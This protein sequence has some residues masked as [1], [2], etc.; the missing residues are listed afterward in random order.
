[1]MDVSVD[2][3]LILRQIRHR[4]VEIC[5]FIYKQEW[6]LVNEYL[7]ALDLEYAKI[8]SEYCEYRELFSQCRICAQ[9]E[10][11]MRLRDLL[12]HELDFC[13]SNQLFMVNEKERKILA[14][15]ARQENEEALEMCHKDIWELIQNKNSTPRIEC[16][17]VGTENVS[18][19]VKQ[20]DCKFR[21]FSIMSPW[22]EANGLL[23]SL[24]NG[25]FEEIHVL[26]F[27]GGYLIGELQRKFREAKI[28]VYLP[29]IDIFQAV[30]H[31][32]SV[33]EILRN[34]NLKFYYDPAC[35]IFIIAL[36]GI[37]K[38]NK[39][40]G[41]YIDQQELRSCRENVA[42]VEYWVRMYK[43]EYS[44]DDI[45]EKNETETVG[46]RINQYI[47]NFID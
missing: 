19:S 6:D 41:I 16:A 7:S 46:K 39:R 44:N 30:I 25:S 38:E 20:N 5:D 18:I 33:S 35:I 1:M 40:V 29:N 11:A 43:G 42:Q 14:E 3:I 15:K 13:I 31:N 28:K 2:G 12:V 21:L 9:K 22:I 17:Y 32:I 23:D 37:L 4:I 10:N 45:A 27:G 47:S 36:N 34:N 24:G 8:L 26:G